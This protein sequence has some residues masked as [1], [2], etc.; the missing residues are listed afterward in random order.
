MPSA[1]APTAPRTAA[2]TADRG[3]RRERGGVFA[4]P[5]PSTARRSRSAGARWREPSPWKSGICAVTGICAVASSP[6]RTRPPSRQRDR[7]PNCSIESAAT[8]ITTGARC[9]RFHRTT[10][11]TTRASPTTLSGWPVATSCPTTS[12]KTSPADTSAT[13][14]AGGGIPPPRASEGGGGASEVNA[15][16]QSGP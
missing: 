9:G 16:P 12:P 15:G 2:V 4:R 8:R 7:L 3:H 5:R 1:T 10:G 13:R 14:S 11:R 6:C